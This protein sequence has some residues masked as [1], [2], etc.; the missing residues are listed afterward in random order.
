M[1]A[2]ILKDDSTKDNEK[3]QEVKRDKPKNSMQLQ[4]Q[5]TTQFPPLTLQRREKTGI[6]AQSSSLYSLAF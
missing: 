4:L 5:S 1:W 2:Q 3:H 6:H